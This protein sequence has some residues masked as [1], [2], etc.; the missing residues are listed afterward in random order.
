M[1]FQFDTDLYRG[2]QPT[3]TDLRTLKMRAGIKTVI[4]LEA[5]DQDQLRTCI[6]LGLTQLSLPLSSIRPPSDLDV[7]T[8][9]FILAEP[10]LRPIYLHCKTGVDRT[11]FIVAKYRI[12]K[13]LWTRQQAISE[14]IN[15]GN[16]LWL[17]WWTWFI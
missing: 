9:L 14:M 3:W 11:G 7:H 16:H 1:P 13:N 4:N 2:P 12:R 8:A 17:R 5:P 15:F 6:S 10:A